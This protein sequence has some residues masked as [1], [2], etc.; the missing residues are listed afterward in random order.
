MSTPSTTSFER[1]EIVLVRFVL[2]DEKGAK[3]RPVVV[4][5]TREYHVGRQ[6]LIVAAVTSNVERLLPG[7]CMVTAWQ[8]AGLPKPSLVTGILRT[9]KTTM[10]ESSFGRLRPKD[11]SSVSAA[12]SASLGL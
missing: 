3:R 9:I 8:A 2:A 12:L 10:I 7:D 4:L 5:S 1:G 11:L 6:E